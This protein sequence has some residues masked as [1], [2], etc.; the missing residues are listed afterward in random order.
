MPT[1]ALPPA[2]R[3]IQPQEGVSRLLFI[4]EVERRIGLRHLA[5]LARLNPG[6]KHY[7]PSFPAPARRETM[8]E[9]SCRRHE[10]L[11]WHACD[12]D[13]WVRNRSARSNR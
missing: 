9:A 3:A 8:H 6:S 5:I 4:W 2:D 10:T 13:T 1:P 7:D 11:R 12:I